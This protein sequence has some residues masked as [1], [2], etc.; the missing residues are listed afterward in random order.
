MF[1][2]E[3]LFRKACLT[4]L[5]PVLSG[6]Q[7]FCIYVVLHPVQNIMIAYF[8]ALQDITGILNAFDFMDISTE[9]RQKGLVVFHGSRNSRTF[10]SFCTNILFFFLFSWNMLMIS[11][12]HPTLSQ[13]KKRNTLC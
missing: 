1:W 5:F 4:F 8:V 3:S 11:K 7:P 2:K 12:K 6:K 13:V 9:N 10:W